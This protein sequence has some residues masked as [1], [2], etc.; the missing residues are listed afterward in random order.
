MKWAAPASG[1]WTLDSTTTLSGASTS[2]NLS[3]GYKAFNIYCVNYQFNAD[4]YGYI[5]FN[6]NSGSVYRWYGVSLTGTLA[7]AAYYANNNT[8][9]FLSN[10][11]AAESGNQ[12]N[13]FYMQLYNSDSTTA[14]KQFL[15]TDMSLS[16]GAQQRIANAGGF[17][18]STT[19][20]TTIQ[21]FTNQTW[22]GGTVLVYGVK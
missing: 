11:Q 20:I 14:Y 1:G 22:S 6:N 18:E 21:I 5:T 19:A 8:A 4:A 12:G 9:F 13:T 17:F 3:A 7:N 10:A 15:I 16:D 2:I